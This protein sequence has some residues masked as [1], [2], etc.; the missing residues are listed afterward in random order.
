MMKRILGLVLCICIALS[1][2]A[3]SVYATKDND[4]VVILFENDVHCAVDGYSKLTAMKKELEDSCENVGVVSC[5]DFIQGSSIGAVSQGEY[6]VQ[7]M[8]LVG[9]DAL[10]LGNH[11]FDYRLERLNELV[12]MLNTKPVCCNFQ[13]I[14]E[15]NPYFEPYKIV[16]YGATDVAYI[17]I[18]TTQTISSS[19]PAQFKDDNGNYIYTFNT[20]ALYD[21]VQ[22][23]IDAAKLHGADYIVALSHI[24]YEEDPQYADV[25]DLIENTDGFDVVLDGHSHSVIENMKLIDEGGNEVLLSSTGTKFKNIGKLTISNG[26]VTTELINTENYTKTD[27][28]VDA[29]IAEINDEYSALGNRK[30]AVSEVELNTHDKDGNRLVRTAETNLGDLC[31][32]AFRIVTGADIAYVNGGGIRA[33]MEK[34]DITFN[35]ILSLFP[36]NNKV[37]VAKISGSDLRDFLEMAM[38]YWP[39]ESGAFPHLSGITFSFNKSIESSVEVDANGIFV[40]V[41]GPYRVYN[42]KILN[43]E[44]G[45]YEPIDLEKEYSIASDSYHLLEQGD[46]LSMFESAK[47][48]QNDGM[49]DVELFEKYLVDYLDAVIGADYANVKN[50]IT[51]TDGEIIEKNEADNKKEQENK[52]VSPPTFDNSN[53]IL[54]IATGSLSLLCIAMLKSYR[55]RILK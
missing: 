45:Q 42:I 13:R 44:S 46:G 38:K 4:T 31:S 23:S 48:L 52:P 22:S 50:N 12:S 51:F 8:N 41:E 19:S 37:V 34:G 17:G 32:D 1:A 47:I 39:S 33:P 9:Y 40:G 53:S 20:E 55:R 24:G 2:L 5:G 7:L 16:S 43:N 14:G 28:D 36:Y 21:V 49:L 25:V 11:E 6:I 26:S 10:T 15:S 30:I 3:V 27:A 29:R 35:D 18:T 54:W